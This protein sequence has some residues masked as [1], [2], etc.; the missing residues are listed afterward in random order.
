MSELHTCYNVRLS[1]SSSSL[2]H[3]SL[4]IGGIIPV[5]TPLNDKICDQTWFAINKTEQEVSP[6]K[7]QKL[8]MFAEHNIIY[9]YLF[10]GIP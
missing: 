2:P 1:S 5:R 8:S 9:T 10:M 3:Q 4:P 7:Q 6:L